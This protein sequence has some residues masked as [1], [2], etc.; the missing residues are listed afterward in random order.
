MEY[1]F[2]PVVNN[3]ADFWDLFENEKYN[4]SLLF[5]DKCFKFIEQNPN[6]LEDTSKYDE[7]LVLSIFIKD[8]EDYGEVLIHPED[9]IEILEENLETQEEF[10]NYELCLKIKSTLESLKNE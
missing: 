6:F 1:N 5:L 7:F 4:M 3:E 8:I 10:E 2:P 9:I